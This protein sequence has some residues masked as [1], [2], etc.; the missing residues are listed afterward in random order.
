MGVINPYIQSLPK[1]W[2]LKNEAGVWHIVDMQ[3]MAAFPLSNPGICLQISL[4]PLLPGLRRQNLGK[5]LL[6]E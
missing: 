3:L 1:N 4:A 2:T 5:R 6:W